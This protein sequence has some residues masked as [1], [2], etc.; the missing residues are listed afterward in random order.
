MI[1][2][3]ITR[4]TRLRSR[5]ARAALT[6]A[7]ALTAALTTAALTT[8]ALATPASASTSASVVLLG[9]NGVLTY[10]CSGTYGVLVDYGPFLQLDNPCSTRVWL[11]Q[12][13]NGSGWSYCVSPYTDVSLPESVSA[14]GNLQVSG[15]TADC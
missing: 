11:H 8:A 14:P 6:L 5:R 7:A 10:P 3:R 13:S 9:E 15:N 12:H 4:T 1:R 2:T